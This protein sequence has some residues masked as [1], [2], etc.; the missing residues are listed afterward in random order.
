MNIETVLADHGVSVQDI[1]KAREYKA[2]I[3]GSLE[4][5]LLNMG[6]FSEE[7]LPSV[8]GQLLK[9]PVLTSE[10]RD[11]WVPPELDDT[12]AYKFLRDN[13]WLLFNKPKK[14]YYSFVSKSPLD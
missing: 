1:E 7:L 5:I 4:K 2:R 12:L 9:S 3:G 6:S 13:G 8:Y 14:K 10:Q 11:S